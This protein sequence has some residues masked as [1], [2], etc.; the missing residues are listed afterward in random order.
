MARDVEACGAPDELA[1][2]DMIDELRQRPYASR[3]ADDAQMKAERH[4]SRL[5]GAFL[6]EV[7]E[8]RDRIIEPLRGRVA[9]RGP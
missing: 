4:H 1:A 7:V 5:R 6:I 2:R 3:P 9:R 8:G